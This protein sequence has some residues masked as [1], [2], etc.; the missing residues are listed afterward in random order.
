MKI[1]RYQ[2]PQG[3]SH[4]GALQP[5]G[6]VLRLQGDIFNNF[7]P[8]NEKADIHKLLAPIVPSQILG[9][10]L[11]YRRH[12]EES[13]AP[14]PQYPVVFMK[15]M[16]TLQNPNDPILLPT[17]LPSSEVDY[18]AELV[19]VIGKTCK[20]VR[21]EHA[22][23]QVL[24]YTCANDVSAR[25]WQLKRGGSQWTRGKN[26]DTFTPLGPLPDAQGRN[27]QSESLAYLVPDQRRGDA[28][29]EHERHDL[30]CANSH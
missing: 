18:E 10:G 27:S 25:D 26:F 19:V 9:I 1:I 7:R 29:L 16:N 13:G 21:R 4:H 22:L 11:N 14:V 23:E 24:G 20:N 17:T 3:R 28:G 15:G 12:A 8:S 6:S 30:R 2:D 5:D